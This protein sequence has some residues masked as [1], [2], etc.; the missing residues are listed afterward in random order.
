VPTDS[1]G[2]D[3]DDFVDRWADPDSYIAAIEQPFGDPEESDLIPRAPSVTNNEGQ[4]PDAEQLGEDLSNVDPELLHL[5]T[6][7][8]LLTNVGVLLISV[9][10][11]LAVFRGL[12]GL[13]I[14]LVVGGGLAL[15]RV[16]QQYRSYKRDREAD[17]ETE[18]NGGS[19]TDPE[20]DQTSSADHSGHNR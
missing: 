20:T 17:S 3:D 4:E 14:G 16:R 7:S 13:G 15:V 8:V 2:D 19:E 1:T 6:V 12:T 11:L 18:S 10:I 9:G 5:F